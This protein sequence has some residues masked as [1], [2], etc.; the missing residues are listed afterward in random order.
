MATLPNGPSEQLVAQQTQEKF[1]FYFL[2]LV[3]ALLVLTIQTSSFG[4]SKLEDVL[5]LGGWLG[6]IVSGLFG[7]WRMQW[8]PII[9]LQMARKDEYDRAKTQLQQQQLAGLR[10]VHVLQADRM[11]PVEERLR[12]YEDALNLLEPII[13][14]LEGRDKVKY[15]VAK[16]GFVLGLLLVVASRSVGA[17]AGLFGYQLV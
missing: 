1:Q 17:I 2:S 10:E 14:E 7:L 5:E 16:Y 9:R 4:R 3:F 6:L 8:E 11:Q 15:A 13:K 12:N